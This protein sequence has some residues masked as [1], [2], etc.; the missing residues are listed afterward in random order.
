MNRRIESRRD[1]IAWA[2]YD[3]ANSAYAAVVQTFVFAAYF[4][5]RVAADQTTGTAQW[6]QMLTI[7]GAIIAVSGP[8]LGAIADQRGGRKS[9][10]AGFTAVCVAATALLWF[11]K[12]SHAYLWPALVL[13]G[14]GTIGSEYANIFYNAMLPS[15]ASR[16]RVGRWSGWAWSLGYFGGLACLVFV[17]LAFVQ[18]EEPWLGFDKGAAA[19][20]VR[21]TF[22][23]T[24][25]W[26]LVFSMPLLLITRDPL[27]TGKGF[28]QAV[29][30]GLTQLRDSVAQIRRYAN[31]VRFLIARMIYIDGLATVF[32]FGGIYAAGTFG[33]TEHEVL[34]FGI[35]LN[36]LAGVGAFAL[37][38]VDD[39]IGSKRTIMLSLLGLVVTGSLI[40]LVHSKTLFWTFGLC[41]GVFVGPV[42]ASSRSFL[43][44]AAPESLTNQMFGLYALSGK[45]TAFLGPFLVGWGTY[46]SGSQ[47]VGMA[48]VILFFV[49]GFVLFIKVEERS[50][51]H[52]VEEADHRTT[53]PETQRP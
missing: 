22:V 13:V 40:L 43:A 28:R 21:A 53:G 41:L 17:L 37:A 34:L 14:I 15:L 44:R 31:I 18:P 24:A 48:A 25:V 30:D 29:H 52:E 42:Q 32:A 5:Q 1:L 51:D 12:P 35:A 45:V 49:C 26:Y 6:G 7:T 4:T 46:L 50:S 39:R 47:R 11:V 9:W 8:V 38:S 36:A 10:I 20:H 23:F 33:M 16:E 27:R 19:E 2:F 3:W